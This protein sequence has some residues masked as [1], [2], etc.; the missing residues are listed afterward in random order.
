MR[1]RAGFLLLLGLYAGIVLLV[2]SDAF[3]GDEVLYVRFATNLTKGFYSPP[4]HLNLWFGPGYPIILAPFVAMHLPLILAKLLNAALLFLGL[5]YFHRTVCLY[6]EPRVAY[7]A[8]LLLGLYLPFLGQ[9]HLL[10][11]ETLAFFLL[12]GF[13]FHYGLAVG[14]GSPSRRHLFLSAFFLGYLALTKVLF[15]Y[16]IIA[17]LVVFLLLSLWKK[18]LRFRQTALISLLALLLCIPYLA[19]TYSLT[20]RIFYW[21]NS[22]GSSLYW[23]STPYENEFGDW[24]G[25]E[26]V[27]DN[28]V[29]HDRHGKLMEEIDNADG[30]A[31]DDRL[32]EV[33]MENITHH[34]LKYCQNILMNVGRLLFSYPFSFTLQKPSTF[35]YLLPNSFLFVLTLLCLFPYVLARKLMPFEVHFVAF[36]FL[37]SFGA[38]ALLSAYDRQFRPLVP[39]LVFW[40]VIVGTRSMEIRLRPEVSRPRRKEDALT[41]QSSR[42]L[43]VSS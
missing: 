21:G 38:S 25:R 35:Y 19:Y 39:L 10:Y 27:R 18:D 17:L 36:F 40:M 34:P 24:H 43:S 12:C 3:Q 14:R 15:G 6:T 42:A 13:L 31:A 22:G 7:V 11:T 4:D 1:F 32:K 28:P 20:H 8:S 33:A 16:I 9:M 30:L 29:L 5:L 2:S 37:L 41:D 26:A 23:M